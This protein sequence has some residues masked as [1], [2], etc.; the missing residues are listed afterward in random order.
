[1]EKKL[2]DNFKSRFFEKMG[3]YPGVITRSMDERDKEALPTITLQELE[4]QF[5]PFLPRY[6]GSTTHLK[7]R[8][9]KKEIV[10]LRH[11][12]CYMARKL[13]YSLCTIGE[14]LAG[15]DHTT[16]MHSVTTF[17]NLFETD[18]SFR[19]RYKMIYNFIQLDY[20]AS[21]MECIDKA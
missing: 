21:V 13:G 9:R 8:S 5:K 6:N 14:Y 11:M 2:I 16:V 3:Y 19:N 17:Q 15:R 4:E 1:M 12:F 20:D 10:E 18:E 7:A